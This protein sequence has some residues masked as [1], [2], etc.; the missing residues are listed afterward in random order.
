LGQQLWLWHDPPGL[1][2]GLQSGTSS[3]WFQPW[4]HGAFGAANRPQGGITLFGTDPR[5]YAI[6]SIGFATPRGWHERHYDP[7]VQQDNPAWLQ[8]REIT[9]LYNGV[10]SNTVTWQSWDIDGP[11]DASLFTPP[12]QFPPPTVPR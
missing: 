5:S 6:R 9:L 7:F 8:A 2:A 10:K 12:A 4:P 3:R 1:Q 11:I